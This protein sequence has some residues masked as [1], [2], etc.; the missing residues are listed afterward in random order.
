MCGKNMNFNQKGSPGNLL[1]ILIRQ[2]LHSPEHNVMKHQIL[3]LGFY[4]QLLCSRMH[5]GW[6]SF[7]CTSES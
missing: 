6:G 7:T 5:T 2:N 1:Q 4:Q 3:L